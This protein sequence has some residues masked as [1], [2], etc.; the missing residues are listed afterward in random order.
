[1]AKLMRYITVPCGPSKSIAMKSEL[2]FLIVTSVFAS[3]VWLF[4]AS[5]ATILAMIASSKCPSSSPDLNTLPETS[6]PPP[7]TST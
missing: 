4:P 3:M 7:V 6:S 5:P 1:M 2:R